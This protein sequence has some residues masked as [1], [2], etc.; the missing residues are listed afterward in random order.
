MHDCL[1]F[2]HSYVSKSFNSIFFYAQ[3]NTWELIAF[4][5]HRWF[6]QIYQF[7][8]EIIQK[9]NKVFDFERI[10][11]S[12]RFE[13]ILHNFPWT[14]FPVK[15]QW[16]SSNIYLYKWIFIIMKHLRGAIFPVIEWHNFNLEY[17]NAK[18]FDIQTNRYWKMRIRYCVQNENSRKCFRLNQYRIAFS[19]LKKKSIPFDACLLLKIDRFLRF[20]NTLQ[21]FISIYSLC[22]SSRG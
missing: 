16:N 22:W 10:G 8:G 12:I 15:L 5:E 18:T 14:S 4:F 19:W 17:W 20:Q 2:F 7:I 3:T 1:Q 13:W 21:Y 11:N 6:Q 9:C